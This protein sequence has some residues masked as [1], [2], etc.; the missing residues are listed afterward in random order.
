MKLVWSEPAVE[1][2]TALHTYI[3]RDSEHYANQFIARI[4]DA[5]ERLEEFPRLGRAVPEARGI[6]GDIREILFHSYRI[7]YRLEDER[8]LVLSVLH[9]SRNL[10]A[11]EPKPWEII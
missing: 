5:A 10:E 1:D 3:A 8:V 11:L 4:L 2:L 7:V 6:A 9:G